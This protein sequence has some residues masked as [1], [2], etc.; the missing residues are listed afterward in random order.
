MALPAAAAETPGVDDRTVAAAAAVVA[1]AMAAESIAG[2]I[3]VDRSLDSEAVPEPEHSK[4]PT[5]VGGLCMP[6]IVAT[7]HSAHLG[8]SWQ[9]VPATF[10]WW[11]AAKRR[12]QAACQAA[13][14]PVL[15]RAETGPCAVRFVRGIQTTHSA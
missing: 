15:S 2:G 14:L 11:T 8:A 9:T 1:A 6:A 13:D 4:H 10:A 3:A 12:R 5:A 7:L